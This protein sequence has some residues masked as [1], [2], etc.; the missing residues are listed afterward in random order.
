[1]FMSAAANANAIPYTIVVRMLLSQRYF[2][3]I[4]QLKTNHASLSSVYTPWMFQEPMMLGPCSV[5]DGPH[6]NN[7]PMVLGPQAM[8]MQVP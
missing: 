2:P 6:A 5:K 3:I 4:K 1:M 7:M 8:Q